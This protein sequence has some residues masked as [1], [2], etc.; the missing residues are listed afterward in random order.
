VSIVPR[1][2]VHIWKADGKC[3]LLGL[4]SF[5]LLNDSSAPLV[6]LQ[7]KISSEATGN[8]IFPF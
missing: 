2:G 1:G 5:Y 7:N 3:F 8:W 6:P 4:G